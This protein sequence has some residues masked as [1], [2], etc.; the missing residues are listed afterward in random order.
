[1]LVDTMTDC[2]AQR[3]WAS[4]RPVQCLSW[5]MPKPVPSSD[6]AVN[7]SFSP[8]SDE[9]QPIKVHLGFDNCSSKN[10]LLVSG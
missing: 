3:L 2:I 6:Q 9:S 8:Q 7:V 5:T 4:Q 10:L 1:M